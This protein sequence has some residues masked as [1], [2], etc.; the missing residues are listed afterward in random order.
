ML[1]PEAEMWTDQ[2]LD[3]GA[4]RDPPHGLEIARAMLAFSLKTRDFRERARAAPVEAHA[5]EVYFGSNGD[6]W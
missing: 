1:P 3:A 5:A 4:L 2:E 6:I